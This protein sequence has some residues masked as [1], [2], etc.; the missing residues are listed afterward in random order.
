LKSV[1]I[2]IPATL[3]PILNPCLLLFGL[4]FG[5]ISTI[6]PNN[7]KQGFKIGDKVAGMVMPTDFNHGVF[8]EYLITNIQNIAHIPNNMSFEEACALPLVSL[9]SYQAL[10]EVAHLNKGDKVLILGGSTATGL[11]GIQLCKILGANEIIVTS[12]QTELC[13]KLGAT[14]VINYKEKKWWEELDG[15]KLDIIYD[16]LGGLESWQNA[17]KVLKEKGMFVTL[18]GDSSDKSSGYSSVVSTGLSLVNRKF[19]GV[20]GYVN[21]HLL[22]KLH[23]NSGL[24][25]VFEW[26]EQGKI[27]ASID[28][29]SP[30]AFTEEGVHAMYNKQTS[31][32]CHGKLV[33]TIYSEE[34]IENKKN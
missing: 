3:S 32:T 12:T 14:R 11:I 19:W 10:L 24:R 34:K 23:S 16:T 17:G 1:G 6:T 9:T 22:I 25:E 26:F 2:T 27:I 15:Q 29:S 28:E 30:Y 31:L 18:V 8:A 21:Y 7:N 33:M 4:I 5:P 13:M 20:C